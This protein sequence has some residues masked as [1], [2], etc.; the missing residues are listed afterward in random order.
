[1]TNLTS[2]L[3]PPRAYDAAT[4]PRVFASDVWQLQVPRAGTRG[5]ATGIRCHTAA[6]AEPDRLGFAVATPVPCSSPASGSEQPHLGIAVARPRVC[7]GPAPESA[8]PHLGAAVTL[9]QVCSSPR[10]PRKL[11]TPVRQAL[12]RRRGANLTV[13]VCYCRAR[14]GW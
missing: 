13:R 8:Q 10:L 4:G 2:G 14:A 9:P 5:R 1:M 12:L 7:G 11:Q 3:E 6:V